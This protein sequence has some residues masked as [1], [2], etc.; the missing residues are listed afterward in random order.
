MYIDKICISYII[1]RQH[2]SVACVTV[3]IVPYKNTKMYFKYS[4]I[5]HY[6]MEGPTSS[7]GLTNRK[8]A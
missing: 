7:G 1:I 8:H 4:Q 5:E 2:V 3:I 6:K